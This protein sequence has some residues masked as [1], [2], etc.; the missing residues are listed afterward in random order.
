MKILIIN[1]LLISGG[2]EQSC[3]KTKKILE[4]NNHEVYYLN[5]DNKFEKNILEV[6][7]QKNIIN[8]KIPNNNINKNILNVYYYLKIRKTIKKINPDKIILNNIFYI[9]TN[10]TTII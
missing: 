9:F 2:A 8:I 10:W 3:L 5:F 7:N 6:E 1:E 4:K